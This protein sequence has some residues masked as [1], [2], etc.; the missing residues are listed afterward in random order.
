MPDQEN[1]AFIPKRYCNSF[2][3]ASKALRC[4]HLSFQAR[5]DAPACGRNG[6]VETEAPDDL[7][8]NSVV[9]R[10]R[11]ELCGDFDAPALPEVGAVEPAQTELT[12]AGALQEQRADMRLFRISADDA[13]AVMEVGFGLCD[14]L[15]VDDPDQWPQGQIDENDKHRRQRRVQRMAASREQPHGRGTPQ[16]RC[17]IEAGDLKSLAK[18]DSGAEKA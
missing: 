18:D 5:P 16:C 4:S 15:P 10:G 12:V 2:S 6:R 17:G 1:L 7:F 11:R 13:N 14:R 9:L 8:K 3:I